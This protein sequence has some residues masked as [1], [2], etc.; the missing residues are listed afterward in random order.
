M[1][2]AWEPYIN[3]LPIWM[4]ERVDRLY[5]DTLLEIRLRLGLP[6]ELV[7]IHGSTYLNRII[8]CDDLNFCVNVSS[9]YSPW[10]STT[11]SQDSFLIPVRYEIF[12]TNS[13]FPIAYSPSFVFRF[14]G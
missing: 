7:T 1:R 6:P 10:A 2:C 12:D 13:F 4:R 9:K 3:I 14:I 5:K 8:T 11:A